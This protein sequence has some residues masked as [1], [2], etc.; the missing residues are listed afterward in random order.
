MRSIWFHSQSWSVV[1][2]SETWGQWLGEHKNLHRL[3]GKLVYVGDGIKVSKE[4]R[5]MPAVKKLHQE[6]DNTNKPDWIRGHYFG[7]LSL[8]LGSADALFA[9]PIVLR[10]HSGITAALQGDHHPSRQDDR[11]MCALS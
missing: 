5:K 4:G 7:C 2:L 1:K 10:I 9:V 6:S 3:Q 8:L 11:P